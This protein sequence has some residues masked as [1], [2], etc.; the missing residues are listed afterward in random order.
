MRY[1]TD[2]IVAAIIYMACKEE[3]YP[4]TFKELSRQTDIIEK[5]IRKFYRVVSKLLDRQEK[6]TSPSELVVRLL[7]LFFFFLFFSFSSPHFVALF[8]FLLGAASVV[9]VAERARAT[10]REKSSLRYLTESLLL[11]TGI[12]LACYH[13]SPVRCG[14]GD[15][16]RGRVLPTPVSPTIPAVP[17][18]FFFSSRP[19]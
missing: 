15:A 12:T 5:E 9:R 8:V 7:F 3:D 14:S 10:Q 1:K 13:K 16:V 18:F 19:G 4:R 11:Q 2:A 17:L 6:R